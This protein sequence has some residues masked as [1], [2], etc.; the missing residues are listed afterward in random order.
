MAETPKKR[1]A[2]VTKRGAGKASPKSEAKPAPAKDAPTK[3]LGEKLSWSGKTPTMTLGELRTRSPQITRLLADV[4]ADSSLGQRL[5]SMGDNAPLTTAQANQIIQ[6]AGRQVS[7]AQATGR[8]AAPK[9]AAK[10][11]A[12]VTPDFGPNS[13]RGAGNPTGTER[14]PRQPAKISDIGAFDE[15]TVPDTEPATRTAKVKRTPLGEGPGKD[16]PITEDMRANAASQR[17]RTVARRRRVAGARASAEKAAVAREE[18]RAGRVIGGDQRVREAAMRDQRKSTFRKG[19]EVDDEWTVEDRKARATTRTA[20][21][22][23]STSAVEEMRGFRIGNVELERIQAL[24]PDQQS[25]IASAFRRWTMGDNVSLK[26]FTA[27]QKVMYEELVGRAMSTMPP[28]ASQFD[29]MAAGNGIGSRAFGPSWQSVVI[30]PDAPPE[31]VAKLHTPMLAGNVNE[32]LQAFPEDMIAVDQSRSALLARETAA[33]QQMGR[34]VVESFD[35]VAR[36][37]PNEARAA[38]ATVTDDIVALTADRIPSLA[39]LRP[40]PIPTPAAAPAAPLASVTQL[41]L[42]DAGPAQPTLPIQ[43]GQAKFLPGAATAQA[44]LPFAARLAPM[45]D[46]AAAV[47]GALPALPAARP[48]LALPA[49]APSVSSG[50][51]GTGAGVGAAATPAAAAAGGAGGVG[52]G[53]LAGGGFAPGFGS[54]PTPPTPG[55]AVAPAAAATT[56]AG[57]M[58]RAGGLFTKLKPAIGPMIGGMAAQYAGNALGDR[59]IQGQIDTA[60]ADSTD[61]G[62]FAKGF[63]DIAPWAAGAAPLIGAALGSNP[64]GWGIAGVG[65]LGYG[66]YNALANNETPTAKLEELVSGAYGL[67]DEAKSYLRSSFQSA[68]T[69]GMGE[70]EAL[71]QVAQQAQQ[72]S[73]QMLAARQLEAE[74]AKYAVTPSQLMTLQTLYMK[75]MNDLNDQARFASA[76]YMNE[77]NRF[78]GL[79]G[80]SPGIGALA[81]Q[82]AALMNSYLINQQGNYRRNFQ[83]APL[84]DMFNSQLDQANAILK[85]QDASANA[86]GQQVSSLPTTDLATALNLQ[87]AG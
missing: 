38:A 55:P 28:G 68:V 24:P 13:P 77:A 52:G 62:Q 3:S 17:D 78:A 31:V 30:R 23:A 8:T 58:G 72:L 7:L 25:K 85:A 6:D 46:D 48:R 41:P 50:L 80:T 2:K 1:T 27:P 22:G 82:N 61:V 74:Q 45:A 81:R 47:A 21:G 64:I 34:P 4:P 35:D 83:M 44:E 53:G 63:G 32:A 36:I 26:N 66:L 79:P 71:A 33:A 67:D 19:L 87:G 59:L 20:A 57:L 65:A 60:G 40:A 18:G 16:V 14:R 56:R 15:P 51:G 12:K 69:G 54:M 10:P 29:L 86:Y 37:F 43:P 11:T 5:L 75:D 76:Q 39:Q 49:A 9:P 73:Q 42:F 70:D 84:R